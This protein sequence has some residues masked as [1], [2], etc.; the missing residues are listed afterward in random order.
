MRN[1][2]SIVFFILLILTSLGDLFGQGRGRDVEGL[3]V[4]TTGMGM[5]GASVRMVSAVD[6]MS[7]TTDDN[8]FYRF[9]NIKGKHLNISFSMLGYGIANQ[10]VSTSSF[11]SNIFVPKVTLSPQSTLIPEVRVLKIVPVVEKG[12]TVQF[13]MGAFSFREHSLLEEALKQLPGFQ[14]LRD[15]TTYYNGQAIQGVRVD[16]QKFFGG[17]LL[18]ATRNL[19]AEFVKQIEVVNDYGDASM[20]KG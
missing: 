15:G 17:D 6:T 2:C 3:V 14:I 4:D 5:S 11:F 16:G 12:D 13:N 20:A 8:G 18:T 7:T 19:P 9:R 10:T 1:I